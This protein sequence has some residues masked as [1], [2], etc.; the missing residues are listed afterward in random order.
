MPVQQRSFIKLTIPRGTNKTVVRANAGLLKEKQKMRKY[1][2]K[3]H[4][5]DN[6]K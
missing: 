3:R 6:E 1:G 5:Y 2:M 4:F